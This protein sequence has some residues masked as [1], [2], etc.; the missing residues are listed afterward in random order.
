M[1]EDE[2]HTIYECRAHNIIRQKYEQKLN[3]EII[4]LKKF[5]NP[6]S[7]DHAYYLAK[8]LDEIENNMKDLDMI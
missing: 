8:F 5:L 1:I 3:F 7:I 4:D 6:D 2:E